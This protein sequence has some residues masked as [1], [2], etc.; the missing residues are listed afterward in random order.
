MPEDPIL[1]EIHRF[2][3]AHAAKF[4]YDVDAI[5]RDLQEQERNEGRPLLQLAPRPPVEIAGKT[6][7]ASASGS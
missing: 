2:R 7:R 1:D 3:E 4:G 5:V 6:A